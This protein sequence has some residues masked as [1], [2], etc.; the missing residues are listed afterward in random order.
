M[1]DDTSTNATA[2][3]LQRMGVEALNNI[4]KSLANVTVTGG[5]TVT[6]VNVSGGT[7]GLTASGGP[8]TTTG[9]ITI[10]GTLDAANGGT[11]QASYAIGDLLFASGASALGRLADVATGSALI[12][13]GIGVA[14]SWGKVGLTT[15]VSGTLAVANGGTGAG[16]LTQYG[17]LIGNGTS[18]VSA[19]A[20]MSDGQLLV[21]QTSS[22]PLPKTISGDV[23]FA[24]SGAATIASNQ[25]LKGI[26]FIIDGGGSAITAGV[27]GDLMI[28]FGCTISQWTLLADQSG[29]IVVDVWKDTYANYPPTVAD[30]IT[31]SALPTISTSTKGQS[32]TLTGWTTAIT[33]G[34]TL[35]FNVNSASTITRVTLTL[36]TSAT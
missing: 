36:T 14:P 10:S 30:T 7:T 29:S 20:A 21:G 2:T 6:S 15:H 12:S 11:G 32:S 19:T 25:K 34:D 24:A 9:T 13:G 26:T 4:V 28:P 22:A 27:K 1:A 5:G 23:T 16:T 18:A 3:S 31:G 8:V 35:R 17:I 33:A